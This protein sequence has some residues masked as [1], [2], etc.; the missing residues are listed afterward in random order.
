MPPKTKTLRWRLMISFSVLILICI[1]V[2]S[3]VGGAYYS[4][5][6]SE[7][8]MTNTLQLLEQVQNNVDAYVRSTDR[9]LATLAADQTLLAYLR[10]DAS[11]GESTRLTLESQVRSILVVYARELTQ[12]NGILVTSENGRYL[13][14][15]F[16]RVTKD[17][18]NLEPWY[19]AALH[20][21]DHQSI[22][23]KPIRRN[24]RNW[25]SYSNDDVV[26][27]NHAVTDPATGEILGVLSVDLRLDE[28][29]HSLSALRLGQKGTI[30]VLDEQGE[31]VYTP[32]NPLVYRVRPQWFSGKYASFVA[33]I[34]QDEM[35]FLYSTSPYT[36]WKTIGMFL[37]DTPPAAVVALQKVMLLVSLVTLAF[38][39][40]MAL[41]LT[42]TITRPISRLRELIVEA[43][44][45]NLNVH[46]EPSN[47]YDVDKLGNSFNAMIARIRALLSLVVEEQRRKRKA[48]MDALQAQINPHFLY[49][50]L[51]TIHWM[52]KEYEAK[53][54][55]DMVA[56]LTKLFRIGLSNGNEFI[57]LTD[58]L[59]HVR[60]YLYIQKIRYEDKL[61]Y[62]FDVDESLLSR[63]V[64]KLMVQPL[65]ENAIYHGIKPKDGPGKIR[66]HI[67]AKENT[68]CIDVFDDG[69]GMP[70]SKLQQLNAA[71]CAQEKGIGFGV[72]NVNERLVM[73]F[74]ADFGVRL[75]P[76]EEG[77]IVSSLR[78][79]LLDKAPGAN[80]YAPNKEG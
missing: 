19:I 8:N 50:T 65:V 29:E 69:V 32:T 70:P 1:L 79:P 78:H 75:R 46:Y 33:P 25:R 53:D 77:G 24:L 3:L 59:A 74:G 45:G 54:I 36:G 41:I 35:T 27:L 7:Q 44:G 56:A 18:L 42:D 16:Y 13:S 51:D 73:Y 72:F 6:I 17:P 23:S 61:S 28:I 52:A 47:S 34:G 49:N 12:V 15:E 11:T 66:V 30:F 20:T 40:V 10:M 63:M 26:M 4:G 68:L 57:S 38:G 5:A 71:L 55:E 60:S 67:Y 58:E 31:V 43:E 64:V 9:H 21:A 39:L 14:N 76:G 22:V 80:S 2:S 37:N 48:E 62:E